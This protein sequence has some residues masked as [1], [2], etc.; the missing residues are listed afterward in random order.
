MKEYNYPTGYYLVSILGPNI[1]MVGVLIWG[2]YDRLSGDKSLLN[3][4]VI[5]FVPLLLL[6]SL[7]AMNQPHRI[8]DDDEKITLYGFFQKHKYTWAEIEFLRIRR[9]IMTDRVLVRIG[10]ERVLG[11]RY[12]LDTDSL[13]GSSELLEKMIPFDPQYEMNNKGKTKRK[14]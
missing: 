12:W 11:G 13:Q 7:A 14:K 3:Q 9:F 6:S 2:I 5:T 10:K 8:T 1:L 4:F